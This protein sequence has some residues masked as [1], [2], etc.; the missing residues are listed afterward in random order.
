MFPGLFR[1]QFA[2]V[3]T[4]LNR[5]SAG[6]TSVNRIDGL[7]LG[8]HAEFMSL[9][10]IGDKRWACERLVH[11]PSVAEVRLYSFV[12]HR[13]LLSPANGAARRRAV[14]EQP[15]VA[16]AE[17]DILKNLGDACSRSARTGAARV[18]STSA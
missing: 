6:S 8:R 12:G 15:A 16:E 3:P 14:G 10:L 18:V 7:C 5:D 11:R 1:L 2:L 4:A 13:L 9:I 17:I